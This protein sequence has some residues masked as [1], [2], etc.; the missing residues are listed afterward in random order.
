M[1][2]NN[3]PIET[4]N[5]VNSNNNVEN[6]ID[7]LADSSQAMFPDKYNTLNTQ[8]AKSG[9][10]VGSDG[11]VYNIVDL[12]RGISGLKDKIIVKSATIPTASEEYDGAV[13]MYTGTTTETYTHGYI[14]ECIG[15]PAY[16]ALIGIYPTKIAFDYTKGDVLSFFREATEDYLQLKSGTFRY[17]LA[18]D[19]WHIDGED[20]EGNTLFTNYRLYTQDLEDAGFVVIVPMEEITD[21]EELEYEI[22]ESEITTYR[23]NR[24]DVQPTIIDPS[25][26][27]TVDTPDGTIPDAVV[28]VEYVDNIVGTIETELE[29]I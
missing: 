4:G 22:T 6:V 29:T 21:G 8:P 20:G 28:N 26:T 14:Y 5:M 16:E 13:Y 2:I 3:L 10:M 11:N 12:L 24:L 27:A 18:G 9:N 15:E 19:I 17:D 25:G 23:W 1:S 7:M